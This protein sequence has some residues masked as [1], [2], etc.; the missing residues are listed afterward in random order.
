MSSFLT[1][2]KLTFRNGMRSH[3]FQLL[4]LVLLFCVVAIP[5]TISG[6]GTADGFIRVSLLYSL[7]AV[8][9]VLALS[10][11]WLGCFVMS[12]DIENYQLHMVVTKPVSRA[13][14]WLAKW[15]GV[16][17][18]NLLLLVV[19]SLAIYGLIL[20]N[21]NRQEFSKEERRKMADEVMVGRRVFPADRPDF[22][23]ESRQLVARKI[24]DRQRKGVDVDTSPKAQE[25]MLADA[26][27][28]VVASY[29]EAKYNQLRQFRFSNLPRDLNQPL[30]LR[31]RP[32][33][34]KVSSEK[35]RMTRTMLLAGV[36]RITG[37]EA[38]KGANVFQSGPRGYEVT[39][40]QLSQFPEQ[41]MSGEFH[42][43]VLLPEW[44]LIT[45]DN[46]VLIGYVNYDD[47]QTSQFLQPADGP[48]LLIKVTGF[49]ENYL[50][51]VLVIA[52]ELLILS[53]LACA[54]GG[55]LTLPTA[56]FVVISYL[57]F[58]SFAV[59]MSGL[60]YIS[61]MA[62]SIGQGI[63][64]VLLWV[65]IPLQ[66]F[67]VTG[68][69]ANGELIEFSLIGRLFLYYFVYRALPW[70][71]FGIYMYWRRELGLVIRK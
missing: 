61:G 48:M 44:K 7:A 3:L 16:N 22:S 43:K 5:A 23:E 12:Q 40:L 42:E 58:G 2:V 69:V 49:L 38:G 26:R 34:G 47:S 45:P 51:A 64:R 37:E 33:V 20:Y 39:F 8:S 50:R 60:S 59:Y 52:L 11:V 54:F 9:T 10:S 21:F 41:I 71:L 57:L 70:F 32:Y 46:E 17:L 28:E 14:I 67:E 24:A 18:I 6:D 30:Y 25:T 15:V 53:G 1:I 65:V 62:D 66:A 68:V 31:Y 27:R 56:I 29:S 63:A 36:P 55:F 35:Q 13:R 19:S 4:L